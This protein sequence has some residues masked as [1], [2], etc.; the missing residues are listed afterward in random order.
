MQSKPDYS[1]AQKYE[2]VAF[3]RNHD[4]DHGKGGQQEAAKRFGVP[5]LKIAA[6]LKQDIPAPSYGLALPADPVEV[7]TERPKDPAWDGVRMTLAR[8]QSAGREYLYGKAWLGWQLFMLKKAHGIQRG[9]DRKS[10]GQ[11]VRLIRSWADIVKDELDLHER[12]AN[13]MIEKFEAVKAK[14]KRCLKTLPGGKNTLTIFQSK[15]PLALPPEQREAMLEIITSL[16]DGESEGS[17]LQELKII[18]TPKLPPVGRKQRTGEKITD[19][20]FA[21]DFFEGPASAICKARASAEYKKLLYM[22]PATTDEE[23]KVSLVFLRDETAAMLDDINE[24]LATH[25]KPAKRK[26]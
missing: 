5:P 24:A 26:A 14:A 23:G 2:V 16:C 18:P 19:E 10:N 9:G 3:V 13:R 20:Q 1:D 8:V 6:W 22:L 17:L 15:N 21:F 25:A 4:A 7:T 11:P 12:T